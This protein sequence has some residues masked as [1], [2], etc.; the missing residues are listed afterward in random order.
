MRGVDP[1]VAQAHAEAMEE[2]VAGEVVT[3]EV[4]D[5]RLTQLEAR[6]ESKIL[7]VDGK[8]SSLEARLDSRISALEARL[9]GRMAALEVR[10]IRWVVGTV[11]AASLT[12]VLALLRVGPLR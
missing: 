1:R 11:G 12:L 7:A 4:F 6:L 2:F 3:K 9:E 5:A 10:I 8:L